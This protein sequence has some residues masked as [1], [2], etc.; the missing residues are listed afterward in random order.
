MDCKM[1]PTD[2]RNSS[3]RVA[4]DAKF[5]EAPVSQRLACSHRTDD[6]MRLAGPKIVRIIYAGGE[7]GEGVAT[8]LTDLHHHMLSEHLEPVNHELY[9][10]YKK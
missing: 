10:L 2:P 9:I 4:R 7:L 3:R 5:R 8:A 6:A 1:C